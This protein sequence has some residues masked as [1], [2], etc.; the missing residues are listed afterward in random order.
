ME[1]FSETPS[2]FLD[3]AGPFE[4][5]LKNSQSALRQISRLAPYVFAPYVSVVGGLLASLHGSFRVT[6]VV[7]R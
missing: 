5:L 6:L 7:C 2:F 3:L 1:A 4:P